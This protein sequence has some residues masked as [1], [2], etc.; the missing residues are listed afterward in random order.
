V[1]PARTLLAAR[2]VSTVLAVLLAGCTS[3]TPASSGA[4]GA[5]F[6]TGTPT[7]QPGSVPRITYRDCTSVIRRELAGQPG[8]DRDLSF[9]C[10]KMPVPLDYADPNGQTLSM[11]VVRARLA[12]QTGRV[13][14]LVINPGGPGASGVDAV[15]ALALQLPV[16]VLRRFDL[17]GFDPRGVG[18]SDPVSCI[19]PAQKDAATAADPDARTNAEYAAQVAL[20]RQ[21]A[22]ACYAR[23]GDK[24]GLFNTTATAR[25]MDML[26]QAVGERKLSY[27]GYSYG[28][29]LGAVYASLFPGQIRTVVLD[30]AVDPT[31]DDV[32]NAEAQARGFEDAF[33]ELA[34][35]CTAGGAPCPLGNNPRRFLTRV[36]A[37]ARANPIPTSTSGDTRKATAGN[38][39]LAAVSALYDRGDWPKLT[40][41]LAEAD[42][43]DAKGV[44]AL[45]DAYNQRSPDGTFSNILDA[46]LA[47]TCADTD[48]R[49]GD[50]TIKA[51]LAQWRTRYPLFGTALALSLVTC[52]VWKAPRHPVPTVHAPSAPTILVVGTR[53]DPATPY[54]SAQH[55]TAALG[56]A[57]LLTWDGD[58][59]TAYPKTRCIAGAVDRYLIS[60]TVPKPRTACPAG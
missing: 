49:L 23:Y 15:I 5:V 38:V 52:Q 31:T 17:V 60:A 39:L 56:H 53:H 14:S 44:L 20:A 6:P 29:L 58:G 54:A 18:L 42:R 19:S 13:G 7:L 34:A 51:K 4:A 2:L 8:G 57:V 21:V 36:L 3:A 30:G 33:D 28:T 43:G 55:L 50:A 22:D 24:L 47:I 25:D 41:A 32:A 12:G 46:N 9:G 1:K 16:E 26:R 27:L 40:A 59:H 48:Q 37:K 45:D 10:G 11:F 35:S